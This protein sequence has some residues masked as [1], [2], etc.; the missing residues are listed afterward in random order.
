VVDLD[1]S[2]GTLKRLALVPTF[3]NRLS[4]Q[5]VKSRSYERWDPTR[6]EMVEH[7][8]GVAEFCEAINRLSRLDVGLDPNGRSEGVPVELQVEDQC[9]GIPGGPVLVYSAAK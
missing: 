4:L 5:R 6:R 1:V 8:D 2:D 9:N 3:L 7:P